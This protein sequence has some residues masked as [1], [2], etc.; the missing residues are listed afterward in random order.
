VL[1]DN[2]L[3]AL[4]WVSNG[5]PLYA[6]YPFKTSAWLFQP[7]ASLGDKGYNTKKVWINSNNCQQ[8]LIQYRKVTSLTSA[9][10]KCKYNAGYYHRC[11]REDMLTSVG[12]P[13][14]ATSFT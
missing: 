12:P 5:W 9:H 8:L 4:V 14:P 6:E 1:Q 11:Y 3:G 13:L 7:A 2:L 10:Y